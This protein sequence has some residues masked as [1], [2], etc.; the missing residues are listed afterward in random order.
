[1]LSIV[2]LCCSLGKRRVLES[3]SAELPDGSAT[4]L[5][6]ANGAGKTT[7]LRC[8]SGLVPTSGGAVRWNG[9][10]TR[11]GGDDW[12]RTVGFAP[13]GDAVLEDLTAFEQ[14]E[15]AGELFGLPSSSA[16]ERAD[17]LLAVL[18]LT[19]RRD[20]Q[21]GSLSSGTRKRL[22]LALALVH[23]PSVV[24]LDEPL[25]GLDVA[26]AF[27]FVELVR[28]L[29]SRGRT[30]VV[31]THEVDFLAGVADSLLE[32]ERGAVARRREAGPQAAGSERRAIRAEE[33]PWL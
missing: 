5:V 28:F 32:L 1:M 10:E 15:L 23:G 18:D 13:D 22:A 19:D 3:V 17:S 12:K 33:L 9:T 21:A 7:L 16:R 6:G 2:E 31:A 25:N 27:R 29:K 4:L 20:A 8:L 24:L 14:L 11:L 30:L 26:G